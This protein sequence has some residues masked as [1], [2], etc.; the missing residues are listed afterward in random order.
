MSCLQCGQYGTWAENP[1]FCSRECADRFND[2]AGA[3]AAP[4]KAQTLDDVI[5]DTLAADYSNT[6]ADW[7]KQAGIDIGQYNR[8][9][10]AKIYVSRMM[11]SPFGLGHGQAL[12]VAHNDYGAEYPPIDR[13]P[14][15][16]RLRTRIAK[17]I[18][19]TFKS[20][21]AERADSYARSRVDMLDPWASQFAVEEAVRADLNLRMSEAERQ[22]HEA[23]ARYEAERRRW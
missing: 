22:A 21:P 7:G 3:R 15:Q 8:P 20:Y 14:L 11:R 1:R 19:P 6:L 16:Q 17:W 5:R 12:R 23:E 2:D 18:E 4:R 13:T 10:R 9:E